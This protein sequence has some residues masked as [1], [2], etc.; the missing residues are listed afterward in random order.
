[1]SPARRRRPGGQWTLTV[2]LDDQVPEDLR[3]RLIERAVAAANGPAGEVI[4]RSRHART[5]KIVPQAHGE[6]LE[7]YVKVLD[8]PQGLERITRLLGGE[9]GA[10]LAHITRELIGAG[11]RAPEVLLYGRH[12]A[13]GREF[14]VTNRVEG[15]GPLRTL[16]SLGNSV[17]HKRAVLRALGQA[18][19]RLHRAGFVHGD[20]TPFNILF[21]CDETPRFTFIDNERT[22]RN[23][24]FGL[25]R[26]QLRNLVQLG[27]FDLPGITRADRVRVYRAY[28]YAMT[29]RNRRRAL[30]L[31]AAMLNR[32][33]ERDRLTGAQSQ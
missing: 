24:M 17:R 3:D 33:L 9:S 4:R 11:F 27:R 14:V 13:S 25:K 15:K 19:A 20:L 18:V 22:R 8:P 7:A 32:R 29:G 5:L 21:T 26:R 2:A 1:M 31:M 28:E 6:R 10:R 16:A 12:R 30:R 23:V